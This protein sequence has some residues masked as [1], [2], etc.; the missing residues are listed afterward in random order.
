MGTIMGEGLEK[1][2]NGSELAMEDRW[3]GMIDDLDLHP[4]T[5]Y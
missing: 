4:Y 5:T 3:P 1:E 2:W